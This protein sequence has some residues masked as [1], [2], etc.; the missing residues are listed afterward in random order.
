MVPLVPNLWNLLWTLFIGVH[1]FLITTFKS[2]CQKHLLLN[3]RGISLMYALWPLLNLFISRTYIYLYLNCVSNVT[4]LFPFHTYIH[5]ETHRDSHNDNNNCYIFLYIP[6]HILYVINVKL[7]KNEQ[8]TFIVFKNLSKT[9]QWIPI[10]LN[11]IQGTM[12]TL[13]EKDNNNKN[14]ND[15]KW[16]NWYIQKCH[17]LYMQ[18]KN[19]KRITT[20]AKQS[21]INKSKHNHLIIN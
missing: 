1:T 17:N 15:T 8:K 18:G 21:I 3:H 12:C 16:S 20:Y 9:I 13:F 6:A 11:Y 7:N 4:T 2:R 5:I 10:E 14:K 19:K